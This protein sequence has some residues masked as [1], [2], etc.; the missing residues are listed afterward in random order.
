MERIECPECATSYTLERLG[1]KMPTEAGKNLQVTVVC[2]VCKKQ[3]DS[4]LES[5][6]EGR[7]VDAPGWVARNILRRKPTVEMRTALKVQ[8]TLR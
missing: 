8:T 4:R 6:L 2:M 5:V 3:F 1:L 7:V